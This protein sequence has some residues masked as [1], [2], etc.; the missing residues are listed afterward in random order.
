MGIRLVLVSI[1]LGILHFQSVSQS[2]KVETLLDT[3]NRKIIA[4]KQGCY[5]VSFK[6]KHATRDDTLW[7]ESRVYFFRET[8]GLDSI[9][10]FVVFVD[11]M[12]LYAYDGNF[13][14]SMEHKEKKVKIVRL[15]K[16]GVKPLLQGYPGRLLFVPYLRCYGSPIEV[17]RLM[18]EKP[19][20]ITL[21]PY[22]ENGLA[23][24]KI[25]VIDSFKNEFKIS[26]TDPSI[27]KISIEYQIHIPSYVVEKRVE[28]ISIF[29]SP[30]YKE[31]NLSAI[32]PIPDSIRFENIF[33][34]SKFE[35]LGY[36]Q[37][38]PD[39]YE[40]QAKKAEPLKIHEGYILDSISLF[41]LNNHIVCLPNLEHKLVVLDFWYRGCY[42]CLQA[43]PRIDT[44]FQKYKNKGVMFYGIN[45]HDLD[46][47]SLKAFVEKRDIHYPTLLDS[48]RFFE[49]KYNLR[50]YPLVLLLDCNTNEVLDMH[51]G[52][53]PNMVAEIAQKIDLFLSR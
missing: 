2:Y 11:S 52:F 23:R 27:G 32:T 10:Q 19:K 53:S 21:A 31:I 6:M 40:D 46:R 39:L 20:A 25:T 34:L 3:V 29:D 24:V 49:K 30:Q 42:P 47:E 5:D 13:Y 36:R 51:E 16:T 38:Q 7:G 28:V 41:D 4:V 9:C 17:E 48:N 1:F 37:V 45:A 12:P 14:F 15:D 18:N 8:C 35:K 50:A 33:S 44:L 26:P 43:L 22:N